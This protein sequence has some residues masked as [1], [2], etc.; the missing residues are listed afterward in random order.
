MGKE[1]IVGST[2]IGVGYIH[3][4][5]RAFDPLRF[6]PIKNV[7]CMSKPN[8]G[9]WGSPVGAEYG[10]DKLCAEKGL[11]DCSEEDSFGF[12]LVDGSKVCHINSAK[13]LRKLPRIKTF[14]APYMWVCLDFERIVV[15]GVDAIQL[16][17]GSERFT[18]KHER[19]CNK[20]YGWDC[21]TIL[22]LNKNAI[23]E[24]GGKT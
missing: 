5:S 9:L 2:G 14:S 20:L 16:N 11:G 3:Y 24:I 4:G 22:V 17:I 7:E 21:D 18:A 19:L 13:D 1:T 6:M 23:I 8:G 10:W 12:T 15:N